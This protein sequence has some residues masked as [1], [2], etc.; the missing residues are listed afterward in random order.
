VIVIHSQNQSENYHDHQNSSKGFPFFGSLFPSTF[1]PT[2]RAM[3]PVLNQT[4]D[5]LL[6]KPTK[7]KK[8]IHNMFKYVVKIAPQDLP[9]LER[10]K[11]N[12]HLE[13]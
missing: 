6:E 10:A 9:R 11:I 5:G 3:N 2:P 7:G 1:S 4:K 13:K 8:T 12:I